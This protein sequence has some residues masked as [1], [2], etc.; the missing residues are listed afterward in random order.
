VL[1]SNVGFEI[2]KINIFQDRSERGGAW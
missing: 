1:K 2:Q